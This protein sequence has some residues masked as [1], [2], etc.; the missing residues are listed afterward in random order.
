MDR[1]QC[2]VSFSAFRAVG[3][4]PSNAVGYSLV[5]MSRS[6]RLR[7]AATWCMISVHR[8]RI[9]GGTTTVRLVLDCQP[10]LSMPVFS[11]PQPIRGL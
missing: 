6:F 10:R 4:Q 7:E 9:L 8:F 11:S 3:V 2:D 5:R 1:Y